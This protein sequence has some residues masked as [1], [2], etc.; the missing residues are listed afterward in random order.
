MTNKAEMHDLLSGLANAG[1]TKE[2][3]P[4]THIK[5]LTP[6]CYCDTCQEANF[7]DEYPGWVPTKETQNNLL[8]KLEVASMCCGQRSVPD[9]VEINTSSDSFVEF[10]C[11]DCST[12]TRIEFPHRKQREDNAIINFIQA[13]QEEL[14]HD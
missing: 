6:H 2:E 8:Y 1:E 3:A 4:F 13:I 11:R 9:R 12:E 7:I 14:S 10:I 5:P